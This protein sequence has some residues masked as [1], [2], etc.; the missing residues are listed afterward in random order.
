MHLRDSSPSLSAVISVIADNARLFTRAEELTDNRGGRDNAGRVLGSLA[1]RRPV[2]TRSPVNPRAI[3]RLQHVRR[4]KHR[5]ILSRNDIC[6]C[7][8]GEATLGGD[9]NRSAIIAKSIRLTFD[10]NPSVVY[11]TGRGMRRVIIDARR[12]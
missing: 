1:S 8:D 2:E 3:T 7:V 10:K 5:V 6:I 12:E 11:A 4:I 9:V